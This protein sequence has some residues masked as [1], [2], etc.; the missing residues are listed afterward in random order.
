MELFCC[1]SG[2]A[3]RADMKRELAH[4]YQDG[5]LA[6]DFI[7]S[8]KAQVYRRKLAVVQLQ[9]KSIMTDSVRRAHKLV[10]RLVEEYKSSECSFTERAV[11]NEFMATN[12]SLMALEMG[13]SG[14]ADEQIR[15]NNILQH[16]ILS[17]ALLTQLQELSGLRA[18]GINA[19]YQSSK[20][21]FARSEMLEQM[22]YAMI[23]IFSLIVLALVSTS[24]A[25]IEREQNHYLN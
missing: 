14:A 15:H 12:T 18:A 21:H 3:D 7:S 22:E 5:L 24:P 16:A 13:I 23:I 20:N 10:C 11:L 17:D 19:G 9:G 1:I 2:K 8:L 4:L 25:N 6:Q